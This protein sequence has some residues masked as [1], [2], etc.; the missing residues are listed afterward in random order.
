MTEEE[1]VGWH[2]RFNRHD[3]G[4]SSGDGEGLG[5]RACY[6]PWGRKE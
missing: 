1:M 6:C 2:H 5:S 4:H 3:L